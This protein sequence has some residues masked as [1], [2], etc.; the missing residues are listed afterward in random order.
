MPEIEYVTVANHAEA[1]NDML[2][3]QGA[4]WTDIQQPMGPKGQPGNTSRPCIDRT[5]QFE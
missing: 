5:D 1:I 2:Y 4:G 3:L